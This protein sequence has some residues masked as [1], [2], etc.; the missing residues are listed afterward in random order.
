MAEAQEPF[1]PAQAVDAEE[2]LEKGGNENAAVVDDREEEETKKPPASTSGED[3]AQRLTPEETAREEEGE[4]HETEESR[5]NSHQSQGDGQTTPN[6]EEEKEE[7]EAGEASPAELPGRQD[8]TGAA[9]G[10]SAEAPA[11][12]ESS[13]EKTEGRD[14]DKA[15]V[16]GEPQPSEGESGERASVEEPVDGEGSPKEAEPAQQ[17]EKP[18]ENRRASDEEPVDREGSAEGGES[19]TEE[20]VAGNVQEEEECGGDEREETV[21]EGS[22]KEKPDGEAEEDEGEGDVE[23]GRAQLGE[24]REP[25]EAPTGEEEL[26]RGES[27]SSNAQREATLVEEEIEAEGREGS[28]ETPEDEDASTEETE[29]SGN[30]EA[31]AEEGPPA[32]GSRESPRVDAEHSNHL[33]GDSAEGPVEGAE[34]AGDTLGVNGM[35]GKEKEEEEEEEVAAAEEQIPLATP[36]EDGQE[37]DISLFVKAGSDGESIGNC[38]FSQ[39][40]FMILWLKGVIFNVTTVDLKRKPADLQKLAPGTNPPFMTFDGDVKIDVNKIEEF[41]E[42]KLAPPRYPKLAPIHLESYSAGNDVFAKFSAFIKNTRKD[43]NENLEKSLLKALRKL[44]NYLNAPLPEEIDAYSTE[45]VTVS[46]RKFLDGDELT[47]ADCN[48]LPKLHIIKAVA[49]KYR[50]FEFPSEMTGIWRYLNNAYARDEFTNTC[51]ADREI[52]F[53]YLDAAKRMK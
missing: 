25:S 9:E 16:P 1:E 23:E 36:V 28:E 18:G 12:E 19:V 41:L 50:N 52:E 45:E 17:E 21:E 35:Q 27:P 7:D 34:G 33:Q 40:L 2:V 47:L 53:A 4:N 49:K 8:E 14:S 39:R 43:A 42:E 24:Q 44:N 6:T 10:E 20:S 31:S 15:P 22:E 32:C 37:H 3:E 11:S 29:A 5:F 38:P 51:P 48:L 13:E 26:L 30:L 46:T